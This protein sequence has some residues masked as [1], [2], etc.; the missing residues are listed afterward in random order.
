MI[1]NNKMVEYKTGL[2][3]YVFYTSGI[4]HSVIICTIAFNQQQN[5]I[6]YSIFKWKELLDI[7]FYF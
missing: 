1:E 5:T 7:W 2:F 6:L 4:L 3:A